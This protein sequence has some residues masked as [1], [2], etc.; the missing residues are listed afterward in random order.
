MNG[1]LI[2][3]RLIRTI[4]ILISVKRFCLALHVLFSIG[5]HF[6]MSEYLVWAKKSHTF[7]RSQLVDLLSRMK[8][9]GLEEFMVSR[10]TDSIAVV[11]DT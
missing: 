2:D 10:T 6:Q 7:R 8:A 3:A 5:S 9:T 1:T 11:D 4:F